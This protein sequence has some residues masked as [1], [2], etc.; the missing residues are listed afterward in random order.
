MDVRG[1]SKI[2]TDRTLVRGFRSV[3]DPRA[4]DRAGVDSVLPCSADGGHTCPRL[5]DFF[6]YA[7]LCGFVCLETNDDS[8]DPWRCWWPRHS[9]VAGCLLRIR[10]LILFRGVFALAKAD[11]VGLVGLRL[12]FGLFFFCCCR[13]LDGICYGGNR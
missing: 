4:P 13:G 12:G 5:N 10:G 1:T 9:L 2:V 8:V 6:L 7:C 11:D 3:T